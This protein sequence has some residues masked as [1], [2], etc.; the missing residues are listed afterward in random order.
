SQLFRP[1]EWSVLTTK[2]NLFLLLGLSNIG[3]A[4]FVGGRFVTFNT[5]VFGFTL[6]SLGFAC[7]VVSALSQNGILARCRFYPVERVALLAFSIYL[8]HK[9]VIKLTH[10]YLGELGFDRFGV[11][12]TGATI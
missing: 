2:G 3:F 11:V 7:L 12:C 6:F 9:P 5:G 10:Y 1:R 4:I 8:T